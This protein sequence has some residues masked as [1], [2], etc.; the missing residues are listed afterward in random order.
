MKNL[1]RL[2]ALLIF[3]ISL[4]ACSIIPGEKGNG[5]IAEENRTVSAFESIDVSGHFD[6]LL[7]PSKTPYVK[8]M[9]DENLLELI[10]TEVEGEDLVISTE[11]RISSESKLYI[12]IGYNELNYIDL[13]GAVD[14]SN[15]GTLRTKKIKFDCSGAAEINM[16]V[17]AS[18]VTLELSG[19]GDIELSGKTEDLYM[20]VSGAAEINTVDLSADNVEIDISGAAYCKVTA[21]K[22]L[23]VEASGAADVEYN[24]NPS[25]LRIDNSGA[26]KVEPL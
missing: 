26:S 4:N 16:D 8:V 22:S 11:K 12:E 2:S 14:I 24:G 23:E 6:V 1:I 17:K 21:N 19:A 13:S 10:K 18:E 20:D 15:Q 7:V 9:A 3:I 5:V 25:K